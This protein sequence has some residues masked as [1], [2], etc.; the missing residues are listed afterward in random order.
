MDEELTADVLRKTALSLR[1][2]P[3]DIASVQAP[4]ARF[5]RSADG[6]SI[7]IVDEAKMKAMA[8]AL[9][10]DRMGDYVRAYPE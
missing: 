6:Q 10:E 1:L 4:V 2:T 8:R 5:G 7:D 3:S 9:R